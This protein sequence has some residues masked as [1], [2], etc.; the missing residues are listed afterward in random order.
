VGVVDTLGRA[1]MPTIMRALL[2]RNA[3]D[4][5]GPA[6]ASMLIYLFMALVL[7]VK[8]QGLFPASTSVTR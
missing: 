7:A 8:P 3:A 2:E 4:A 6:L 5:A 1:F